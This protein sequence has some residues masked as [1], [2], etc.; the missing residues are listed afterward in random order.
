MKEQNSKNVKKQEQQEKSEQNREKIKELKQQKKQMQEELD[1][2]NGDTPKGRALCALA[3]VAALVIL[4]GILF[5]LIK[6]DVGG[7]ASET[8]A[9]VIGDVP[10][11]RNVLPKD[12]QSLSDSEIAAQEAAAEEQAQA[13]A[14]AAADSEA[15]AQEAAESEA[16]ADSEAAAAAQAAVDSEAA[17]QAQAE[18]EAAAEEQAISDAALEDY[19]KTY[20]TMKAADAAAVFDNMMPDQ[21]KL[22]VKI[23]QNMT[24]E[25]RSAILAK[26]NTQNASDITVEMDKEL[27]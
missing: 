15:A 17:A 12:L 19:V 2:L 10:I 8:L 23:L 5:A 11:L 6:M 26:M 18:S 1:E 27:P 9:P 14:Q 20:S 7:F 4:L 22:V 3:F 21:M 24:A 13:A 25:Q 16:A